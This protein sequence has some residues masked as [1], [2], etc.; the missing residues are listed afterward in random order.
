MRETTVVTP[1]VMYR[2]IIQPCAR[3]MRFSVLQRNDP[4]YDVRYHKKYMNMFLMT[5]TFAPPATSSNPV[6]KSETQVNAAIE[7]LSSN[8]FMYMKTGRETKD[9]HWTNGIG[10]III[11]CSP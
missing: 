1:D 2:H 11:P 7:N 3:K 5:E 9:M 6:V 4:L 8:Y 10:T